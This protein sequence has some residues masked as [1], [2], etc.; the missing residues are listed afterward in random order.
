MRTRRSANHSDASNPA[1]VVAHRLD[2]VG[3]G[4]A[5]GCL[6]GHLRERPRGARAAPGVVGVERHEETRDIACRERPDLL[7]LLA[8]LQIA[9]LWFEPRHLSRSTVFLSK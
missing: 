5:V 7:A 4:D 9:Y 2:E 6:R 3:D 1:V 8:R